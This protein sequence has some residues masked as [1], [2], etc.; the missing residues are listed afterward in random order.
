[1]ANRV[2]IVD[3]E[4]DVADTLKLGLE[5]SGF[6][7]QANNDAADALAS[8]RPGVFDLVILDIRMPGMTG[9]E[10][11]RRMKKV[12][13]D[14]RVCFLT[15]FEMYKPEFEKLFPDLPIA[16]FLRKPISIAELVTQVKKMT[17]E[18][19]G[20]PSQTSC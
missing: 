7:V 16:G 8:Y 5:R 18:Q 11:F 12:D 15:A 2:L 1:M 10:L 20:R 6:T 19:K 13:P 3:D 4:K 9:F 14:V 17:A